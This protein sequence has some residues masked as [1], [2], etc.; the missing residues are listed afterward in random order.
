[1]RLDGLHVHRKSGAQFD[2]LNISEAVFGYSEIVVYFGIVLVGFCKRRI[3]TDYGIWQ[4]S[5]LVYC[6]FTRTSE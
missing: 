5:R 6:I 3:S 2:G 4:Y 1:M